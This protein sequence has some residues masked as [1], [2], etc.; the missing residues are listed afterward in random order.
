MIKYFIEQKLF[1]I[2]VRL[3]SQTQCVKFLSHNF[4]NRSKLKCQHQT[5]DFTQKLSINYFYQA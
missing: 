1:I 5:S 3:Y 2:K 4:R